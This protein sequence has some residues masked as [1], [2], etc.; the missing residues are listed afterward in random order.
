MSKVDAEAL[1]EAHEYHADD[2]FVPAS[3]ERRSV[4]RKS[5]A[6]RAKVTVPGCSVLPGHTVDLS[7]V[8]ASITVPFDLAQGQECLI[9]FELQACGAVGAFHIPA[10]VR[11]CVGMGRGRFR[12]GM[13]FGQM[14]A[15]TSAFIEAILNAPVIQ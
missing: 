7:R 2:L 8:G 5:I 12:I 1:Y 6:I 13:R 14:D 10:E 11:Y 3:H 9:D 4:E 15:Q